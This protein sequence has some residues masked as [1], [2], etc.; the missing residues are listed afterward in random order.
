MSASSSSDRGWNISKLY[1]LS[2]SRVPATERVE[3]RKLKNGLSRGEIRWDLDYCPTALI[4]HNDKTVN[5]S[6]GH[7]RVS[8]GD[9]EGIVSACVAHGRA[10]AF[11]VLSRLSSSMEHQ[12]LSFLMLW[13]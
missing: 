5:T 8:K 2:K 9:A 6:Y 10:M 7:L 3:V 12:F 4:P 13:W 1:E 11:W